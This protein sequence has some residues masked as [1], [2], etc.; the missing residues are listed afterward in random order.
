MYPGRTRSPGSRPSRRVAPL[1]INNGSLLP[2]YP[3]KLAVSVLQVRL[4][5][6]LPRCTHWFGRGRACEQRNSAQPRQQARLGAD[7]LH[8]VSLLS[9]S[10]ASLVPPLPPASLLCLLPPAACPSACTCCRLRC[11]PHFYPLPACTDMAFYSPV[12]LAVLCS[13]FQAAAAEGAVCRWP[14]L[15]L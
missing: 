13:L 6:R 11:L 9:P 4:R 5:V 12:K 7:L 1:R 8:P 3:S 15:E 14:V 10:P 2:V